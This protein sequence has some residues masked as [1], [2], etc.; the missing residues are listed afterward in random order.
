LQNTFI[1][2]P[3]YS[4]LMARETMAR[5]EMREVDSPHYRT[6]NIGETIL[7]NHGHDEH[8]SKHF[9]GIPRVTC[10]KPRF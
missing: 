6:E 1:Y 8:M 10:H 3:L 4:F 9:E 2:L 5:K 7:R